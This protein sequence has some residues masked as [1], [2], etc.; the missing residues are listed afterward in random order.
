MTKDQYLEMMEQM[1][2]EPDWDKCPSDW[3]DFPESVVTALNIYNSLGDRVFADVGYTG[4]DYTN[5]DFLLKLYEVEDHQKQWIHEVILFLESRG[6]EQ[7]QKR[8]KAE[9]DRLKRK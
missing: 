5:Y 4:K 2:E 6:I 1:G 3:E 7:S 8:L 9:H